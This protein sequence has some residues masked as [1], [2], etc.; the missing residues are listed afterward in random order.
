MGFLQNISLHYR[1]HFSSLSLSVRRGTFC[2]LV[3][4]IVSSPL[5][6]RWEIFACLHFIFSVCLYRCSVLS[7]SRVGVCVYVCGV[8]AHQR[9]SFFLFWCSS[10]LLVPFLCRI[11]LASFCWIASSGS[12][13]LFLIIK[14]FMMVII[15][16]YS[17]TIRFFFFFCF[18]LHLSSGVCPPLSVTRVPQIFPHTHP[19]TRPIHSSSFAL[20]LLSP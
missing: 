4:A 1:Y 19:H 5:F 8:A 14:R 10:P 20:F 9:R 6:Y 11:H 17:F 16:I 12:S 18:L 7:F 15:I 2:L 13:L 3:F